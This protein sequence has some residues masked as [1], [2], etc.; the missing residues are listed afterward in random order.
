MSTIPNLYLKWRV[1]RATVGHY[2][3]DKEI[4]T[5]VFGGDGAAVKF[6]KLV[7]GD[8]GCSTDEI[9]ELVSEINRLIRKYRQNRNLPP[10]KDAALTVSDLLLPLYEFTK[11]LLT[12]AGNLE[13]EVLDRAH[14]A[15]LEGLAPPIPDKVL[16]LQLKVERFSNKR[17]FGS[18]LPSGGAGPITFEPDRHL[19]QLLVD[20]LPAKPIDAYVFFTRD[21]AP[22][23]RRLWEF[24]WGET[25]W[26][27]PSPFQPSRRATTYALTPDPEPIRPVPGRFI[28]TAI[29]V[30]DTDAL[31]LLDPRECPPRSKPPRGIL[32]EPQTARFL[33]NFQHLAKAKPESIAVAKNEYVVLG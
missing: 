27:L 18:A 2:F 22:M 12:A 6:S 19:G 29:F 13:V 25:V 11:R 23:K 30:L 15:V 33:V 7:H 8:R 31:R 14:R 21:P 16:S 3:T 4:A 5:A 32:D 28:V 9:A 1:F 17:V 26:W 10:S 20:D 24:E